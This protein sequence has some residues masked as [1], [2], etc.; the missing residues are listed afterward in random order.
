MQQAKI[1]KRTVDSLVPAERDQFLQDTALIGFF[2]EC[3]GH[4]SA[5]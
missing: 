5:R 1:S 4:L 2:L 3:G